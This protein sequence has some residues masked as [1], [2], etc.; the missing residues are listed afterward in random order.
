MVNY[1]NSSSRAASPKDIPLFTL[2][3][4]ANVMLDICGKLKE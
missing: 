2:S 3:I 4:N 1:F